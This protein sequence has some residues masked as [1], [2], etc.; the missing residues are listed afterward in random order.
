MV[1]QDSIEELVEIDPAVLRLYIHLKH[2]LLQFNIVF[3]C[4]TQRRRNRLH[5]FKDELV[6]KLDTVLA[7]SE[8]D[9]KQY[10]DLEV[11]IEEL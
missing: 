11:A 1:A 7:F 5:V 2:I 6:F 4:E 9:P 8:L 10:N 3:V